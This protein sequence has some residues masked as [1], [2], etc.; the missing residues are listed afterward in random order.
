M[1]QLWTFFWP[2]Y[3]F[4]RLN[5]DVIQAILSREFPIW[6]RIYDNSL[7]NA[8][9]N[10]YKSWKIDFL[11]MTKLPIDVSEYQYYY[12]MTKP[13]SY[14]LQSFRNQFAS[15]RVNKEFVFKFWIFWNKTI[16]E[17]TSRGIWVVCSILTSINALE[18]FC[19]VKWT[20]NR[21]VA[22]PALLL[23]QF[24]PSCSS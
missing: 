21:F 7:L 2:N 4:H 6:P 19:G 8:Q 18:G 5:L 14:L 9:K 20:K 17:T 22:V 15:P 16:K 1:S 23:G 12:I 13:H 11:Q 24:C 10:S 3:S